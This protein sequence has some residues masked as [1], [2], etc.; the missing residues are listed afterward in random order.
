[1]LF[2]GFEFHKHIKLKKNEEGNYIQLISY[3]HNRLGGLLRDLSIVFW[4]K[5]DEYTFDFKITNVVEI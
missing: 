5:S 3:G 2:K 4:D 1:M